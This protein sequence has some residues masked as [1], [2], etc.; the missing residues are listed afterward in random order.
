M[1]DCAVENIIGVNQLQSIERMPAKPK[2]PREKE[3]FR[4]MRD[5]NV[6]I[7]N[8]FEGNPRSFLCLKNIFVFVWSIM[9]KT[10]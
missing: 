6:E 5:A 10:N 1:L 3:R 7:Y 2:Y 9:N 8:G 4:D